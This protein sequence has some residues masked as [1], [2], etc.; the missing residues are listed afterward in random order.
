VAKGKK[1]NG[2]GPG[3][4]KKNEGQRLREDGSMIE[5]A[6]T[7]IYREKISRLWACD[8]SHEIE[9]ESLIM[10]DKELD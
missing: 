7:A 8:E 10:R 5:D 3:T 4:L 1:A 6:T 9:M 2:D